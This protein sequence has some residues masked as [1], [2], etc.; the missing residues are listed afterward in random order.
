MQEEWRNIPGWEW[1]YQVSNLGRFAK[2]VGGKRC[3]RKTTLFGT[4]YYYVSLFENKKQKILPLH[5]VVA[6]AFIPKY[7]PGNIANHIDGNRGNNNVDNLEWCTQ[8]KNCIHRARVLRTNY[9]PTWK[10]PVLCVETGERFESLNAAAVSI[11]GSRKNIDNG[12]IKGTA[13]GIRDCCI[14][15]VGCKTRGGYHWSFV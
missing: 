9:S 3:I 14:G 12:A 15:K 10:K 5:R 2:I 8:R 7:S 4:G 13:A 1:K 6:E 11:L